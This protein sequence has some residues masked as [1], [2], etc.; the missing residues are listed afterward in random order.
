M[1]IV[2]IVVNPV[3]ELAKSV[4]V[5]AVRHINYLFCCKRNVNNL[6][7]KV[8]IALL[9][10]ENDVKGKVHLALDNGDVIP[11]S[12]QTLA[13]K[14]WFSARYHLGKES[15]K[16]I[17]IIDELL[18]ERKR[19]SSVAN[20]APVPPRAF[21]HFNAFA[22]RESAKKEVIQALKDNKTNLVRI[23][24]MEGVG[25]TTL[26]KEVCE[27]GEKLKLFDKVVVIGTERCG[28]YTMR[29]RS[30][31][32]KHLQSNNH[33]KELKSMNP[34][35]QNQLTHIETLTDSNYSNW[36]LKIQIALGYLDFD[37][38]LTEAKPA[39]L[40][41]TSSDV[42]KMAYAKWVKANKMSNPIIHSSID[43]IMRGSIAER[44]E[45]DPFT[46]TIYREIVFEDGL[47]TRS[48]TA[49]LISVVMLPRLSDIDIVVS[50]VPDPVI[51]PVQLPI[52]PPPV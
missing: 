13:R 22:S 14:G 9:K 43:P 17:V 41:D 21:E 23:Y 49:I 34:M 4:G 19:F 28:N 20:R 29:K 1:E 39:D 33:V 16:K 38:V 47:E 44:E 32:S 42:E 31:D 2:V 3:I 35:I 37:F 8:Q 36:K 6:Q 48:P 40:T 46:S 24:G 12:G 52:I 45:G 18:N 27:E 25:K 5:P 26:V 51:A 11:R 15:R 10:L 30:K 7:N 50:T